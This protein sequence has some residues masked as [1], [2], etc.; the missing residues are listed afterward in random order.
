MSA[1]Q[2]MK[3]FSNIVIVPVLG[4]SCV[5]AVRTAEKRS[6]NSDTSMTTQDSDMPQKTYADLYAQAND[7]MKNLQNQLNVI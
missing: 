1:D 3:T 2:T 4:T 7:M 5:G 6:S